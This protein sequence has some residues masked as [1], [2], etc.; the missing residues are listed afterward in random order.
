MS[1]AS[2]YPE[3]K[4]A[5][6]YTKIENKQNIVAGLM[7]FMVICI[8]P[9]Y[10][11]SKRY[12]G[13]TGHKYTFFVIYMVIILLAAAIIWLVRI[14]NKP[15]LGIRERPYLADWA[16]LGLAA[17]TLISSLLSPYKDIMNVWVGIPEPYGRYDGAITQLLYIAV[18]LITAHWYKP[19]ERHF[20]YFG[21]SAILIS[22]IGIFQFYGMDF[23]KLWPV[24]IPEYRVDN[25]YNIYFRS[26]LGN[27]NIVS[28][29][30]CVSMLL[31]GFLY[32]KMKS[33]WASLWLAASALSFWL[34]LLA[35]SDSGKVGLLVAMLLSIPFIIES[36]K[37]IG[38]TLIM[39]SSWAAAFILQSLFY[40]VMILK[41]R[42][43]T[44]LLPFILA[45]IVLL[46]VGIMLL[47]AGKEATRESPVRWKLGVFLIVL[48]IVA[49]VAGV[50]VLGRRDAAEDNPGG[51]LYELREILH[52]NVQDEFGTNRAYIWR[53]ALEEYPKNPVIGTGPDTFEHVFPAEA[54]LKYD[55]VYDN[56]HNEYLQILICLGAL[57]LIC[58][59]VFLFASLFKAIPKALKN[60]LL[61][62]VSAAFV[63]YCVQA[64]FNISMP[65]I[66]QM[67]WVLAGILA[68]KQAHENSEFGM[69]N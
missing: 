32:V 7:V 2:T 15:R 35:D 1:K 55:E 26:T 49:G 33:K 48:C 19:R 6:M 29:Y 65:A 54:Q 39:G 34:M 63:G 67:P 61:M 56:A 28:T 23:F 20:I 69:Q 17:V 68:N 31:C 57:G 27:V 64:F 14:C 58:Y 8:Q 16:V 36:R 50:E 60:P 12:I 25:L 53:I 45:A 10:F 62:A 66:G 22:L 30:V 9:L 51:I 21:I 52:G 43:I 42:T 38:R 44:G 5:A 46:V 59:L 11:N 47:R 24:D 4:K 3:R 37:T 13:L 18:F 41:S 40:D